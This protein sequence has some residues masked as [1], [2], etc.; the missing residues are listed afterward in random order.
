MALLCRYR[1]NGIEA[2]KVADLIAQSWVSLS[3]CC[4]TPLLSQERCR[5]KTERNILTASD[6]EECDEAT[7]DEYT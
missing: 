2:Q 6:D 3:I 5:E 1:K 7:T 4:T